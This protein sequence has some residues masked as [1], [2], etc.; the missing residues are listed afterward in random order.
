MSHQPPGLPEPG[1]S[2]PN[3]N[4]LGP[5]EGLSLPARETQSVRQLD[6]L[7]ADSEIAGYL[8]ESGHRPW[9]RQRYIA[10]LVGLGVT[11]CLLVAVFLI[12]PGNMFSRYRPPA[13]QDTPKPRPYPA[14]S[15]T[16]ILFRE[17]VRAINAD[18]ESGARW[19]PAF[20]KLREL[21]GSLQG[22]VEQPRELRVWAYTEMLVMLSSRELPPDL[23]SE[24]YADSVHGELIRFLETS[25]EEPRPFRADMAYVRILANR[26]RSADAA[27]ERTKLEAMAALIESIRAAHGDKA[28]DNRDLLM[29]EAGTHTALLP[30]EYDEG[31][32]ALDYHWRRAAHAIL[33]LYE[34]YGLNDADVRR[35]DRRRWEAVYRYFDYTLFTLDAR[36]LGRIASARLDGIDYTRAEIG[37]KLEKLE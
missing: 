17:S 36:R 4:E 29:A 37:A 19:R 5:Y 31:N 14:L 27:L 28:D 24:E 35:L 15:E 10:A 6:A 18:M 26:T 9:T 34:L 7:M 2:S 12:S 23:F 3:G 22:G 1:A 13:P 16:P 25:P 32:R 21:L 20:E 8:G 11:A 33:R 30:P